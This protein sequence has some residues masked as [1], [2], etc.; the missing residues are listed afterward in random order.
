M[1]ERSLEERVTALEER[2]GLEA[3]L[4]AAQDR[5]LA[6]VADNMR[7]QT[8]LIQ[9]LAITQAD[10]TRTLTDHTATLRNHTARFR[11]VEG[12]LDLIVTMLGRLAEGE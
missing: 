8:M 9:A 10:H 1:S 5:D 4:R 6:S 3:G 2:L 12:K 7:A 11:S